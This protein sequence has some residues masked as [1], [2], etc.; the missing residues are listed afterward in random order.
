[1][2]FQSCDSGVCSEDKALAESKEAWIM[3]GMAV[4]HTLAT[5][6]TGE[7]VGN[8]ID[9]VSL[10]FSTA[11][12]KPDNGGLPQICY[13]DEWFTVLKRYEFDTH[14]ATQSV[15]VQ[16]ESGEKLVFVK[17]SPEAIRA[18]SNSSTVPAS[19]DEMLRTSS[20]SGIYQI[21]MAYKDFDLA[22][23]SI[24]DV[25]RDDVEKSLTFAG[26]VKFQNTM[27]EDTPAVLQEL[28]EGNVFLA[29]ITGDSV[30]TGICIAR[31]SGMIEENRQ[32]I[33]GS[34]G[35][36][37][38]IVWTD[39]ASDEVVKAPQ[40]DVL[41]SSTNDMDLAV[42]GDAWALLRSDDPKY[43]SAIAKHVKVFGRCNP[44]DKVSVVSTFVENGYITLM[45]GDG[46]NDCGALKS[47]HVGVALSTSEAS[48][49][50]PFTSLDKVISSVPEV[51]REGRCALASAFAAYKFYIIYGQLES[52][53]QT[54]NAYLSIT[55]TE[56]CWVFLDGIWS[57]T[58][59]F[60]LPLSKAAKRLSP[61]RPTASLLGRHTLYSAC[62]LLVLNFLFLVIALLALFSQDWFQCRKWGSSDVSNILIIGDNYESSVIFIVGGYQYTATAIALNFGYSFRQNWWKNYVFVFFAILWTAFVFVMTIYP[63]KFSCI[64]RVN[65]D[66][67]VSA[68]I[69]ISSGRLCL[70]ITQS[71]RTPCDR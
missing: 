50:A 8:Q 13:R 20:R 47:A 55:F 46:Q 36:N 43:A 70:L 66:N 29:M 41:A 22:G 6:S 69:I 32:V 64:W 14:R 26:F 5:T 57:I 24:A 11:F 39:E 68:K 48:I 59:A 2:E 40:C 37:D 17:G 38:E 67:E 25:H 33:I 16:K 23:A 58:L 4:C 52:Y 51:L 9:I 30:L 65:C 7:M 31:E 62:G 45:C 27:K 18:L 44:T 34:K 21:A 53:F 49:V 3:L 19:F 15:I 63:S 54:I 10:E 28:K 42:S 61:I 71:S 12:M 35:S 56:W 1:M 60:S